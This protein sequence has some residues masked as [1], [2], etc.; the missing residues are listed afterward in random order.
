M[1]NFKKIT[2]IIA[3]LLILFVL[4]F[5]IGKFIESWKHTIIFAHCPESTLPSGDFEAIDLNQPMKWMFQNYFS[6]DF[7]FTQ[8]Y[9]P[10]NI[11]LKDY[12]KTFNNGGFYYLKTSDGKIRA[13][14]FYK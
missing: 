7:D 13:C 2:L 9:I 1:K 3:A 12:Y 5:M 4:G 6:R 14:G 8:H 10:K 11:S